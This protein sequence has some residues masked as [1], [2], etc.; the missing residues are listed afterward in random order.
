MKH[1][2]DQMLAIFLAADDR[3]THLDR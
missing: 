1:S 2:I 3:V